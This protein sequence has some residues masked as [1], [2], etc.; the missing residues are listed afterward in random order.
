[1]ARFLPHFLPEGY[2]HR[3]CLHLEDLDLV[4]LYNNLLHNMK[5]IGLNKLCIILLEGDCGKISS[6]FSSRRLQSSSLSSSGRS[7]FG[8]PVQFVT[9]QLN[10]T[11]I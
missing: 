3:H 8:F 1:V 6:L 9:Q 4:F 10:K 11:K 7:R 2:N 5:N